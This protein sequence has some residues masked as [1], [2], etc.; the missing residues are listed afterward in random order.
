MPDNTPITVYSPLGAKY[1]F[2]LDDESAKAYT[3]NNTGYYSKLEVLVKNLERES[4]ENYNQTVAKNIYITSEVET[5]NF[6]LFNS[7]YDPLDLKD[8]FMGSTPIL[9]DKAA[10][11]NVLAININTLSKFSDTEL[12]IKIET[13][14]GRFFAPD[15]T[16]L[17]Q[18]SN[19]VNEIV[20]FLGEII[21]NTDYIEF[22]KNPQN[23]D[24]VHPF[25]PSSSG[26]FL[27]L[28]Y[29]AENFIETREK[30]NSLLAKNNLTNADKY[31]L[32]E[33]IN[34][35]EPLE[36]TD[37]WL[38]MQ[39][40]EDV[41][42]KIREH[43]FIKVSYYYPDPKIS[44]E[45]KKEIE[46]LKGKLDIHADNNP[47]FRF[48][49][50]LNHLINVY[51]DNNINSNLAAEI[52]FE[53]N[54]NPDGSTRLDFFKRR[55]DELSLKAKDKLADMLKE[56]GSNVSQNM[57]DNIVSIAGDLIKIE[58]MEGTKNDYLLINGKKLKVKFEDGIKIR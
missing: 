45:Q 1:S 38:A 2:Y 56:N 48:I 14:F 49:N 55:L 10:G 25:D 36:N 18:A 52:E 22:C 4:F 21:G 42:K 41:S 32:F 23:K 26:E 40:H 33:F 39:Q 37:L 54:K 11:E 16:R 57:L 44:D 19:A 13:S 5:N 12:A 35:N 15:K 34:K 31:Q 46:E 53:K 17:N 30:F 58:D 51:A 28:K 24:F 43:N 47:Y 20:D 29:L 50:N 6:Y 3:E 27:N 9:Q 8:G 7:A